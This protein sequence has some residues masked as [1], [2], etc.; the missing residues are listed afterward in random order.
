MQHRESSCY[1]FACSKAD[2]E[3]EQVSDKIQIQE[4]YLSH[5]IPLIRTTMAMGKKL[6]YVSIFAIIYN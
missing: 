5:R 4:A 1:T 6:E 2:N 3:K